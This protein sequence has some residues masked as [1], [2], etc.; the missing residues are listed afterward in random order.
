MERRSFISVRDHIGQSTK[1]FVLQMQTYLLFDT[2]IF[3]P[4]I[5]MY[6]NKEKEITFVD[7]KNE[8]ILPVL[9]PF[10]PE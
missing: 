10:V 1:I 2:L 8:V 6:Q 3:F 7:E 4:C 9:F 5:S